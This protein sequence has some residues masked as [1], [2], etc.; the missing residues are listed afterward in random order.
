MHQSE[1]ESSGWLSWNYI[2]LKFID[3]WND[4]RKYIHRVH[5]LPVETMKFF[6][7]YKI[8]D[9]TEQVRVIVLVNEV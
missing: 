8:S 3:C 6:M 7:H 9:V 2:L 4:Y 1:L 5:F